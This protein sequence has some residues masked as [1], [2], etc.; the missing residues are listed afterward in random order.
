MVKARTVRPA[1]LVASL[2][3]MLTL[4]CGSDSKPGGGTGGTSGTPGTGGASGSSGTGGAGGGTAGTGGGTAGAGGTAGR[5][6]GPSGGTGGATGGTGGGGSPDGGGSNPQLVQLC[7][8]SFQ[9]QCDR[10]FA[11]DPFTIKSVFGDA[12]TCS[13][14]LGLLCADTMMAPGST[15]T[16]QQE[17]ACTQALRTASCSDLANRNVAACDFKGTRPVGGICVADSQCMSGL[18]IVQQGQMCGACQAI[19]P[20]GGSCLDTSQCAPNLVCNSDGTVAG[21]CVK[22]GAMAAPCS[23][24]QPCAYGLFC[25]IGACAPV[26]GMGATCDPNNDG[27]DGSKELYCNPGAMP[28][29]TAAAYATAGMPCGLVNAAY[30]FCR[31]GSDCLPPPNVPMPTQGTCSPVIGDGMA[32]NARSSCLLPAQCIGTTCQIGMAPMCN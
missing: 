1:T 11:C 5:D 29:C 21:M 23:D 6:G 3:A 10:L 26:L 22:P 4:A 27:C 18:C 2:V 8:D 9:V 12:A 32:C 16:P 25:N 7:K 24:V 19:Q 28:K 15:V 14:R 20:M 31:N 30:T 13:A 17:M